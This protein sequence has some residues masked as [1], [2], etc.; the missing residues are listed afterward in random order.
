MA[1]KELKCEHE[2]PETSWG[3]A[4]GGQECG[5]PAVGIDPESERPACAKHA[6]ADSLLAVIEP[7]LPQD[8]GPMG[9]LAIALKNNAAI[10]VIE[11]LAALQE[12]A[13]ARDAE[14]QFNEAMSA[15]QA[16]IGRISPDQ[17]AKEGAKQKWASYAKLDKVLRPIYIKHG[18]SL[19]FNSGVSPLPETVIVECYVSHRG[20]HTRKY[21]APPMPADGKGAKGGDVMTKTF[22]TGAGMSY[23]ARY[24]LKFI[25]NIAVGEDDPEANASGTADRDWLQSQIE[26]IG[27]CETL[28]GLQDAYTS[29]ANTA[30]NQIRDIN[31]Y[32]AIKKAKAARKA[33]LQKGN[34]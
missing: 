32:D 17:Q 1:I 33:E 20:G 27:R 28:E 14:M 26:E 2:S 15:A 11:R 7:Q 5:R 29:A 31:A 8:S 9:L 13:V 23:G 10:D 4:D 30:L 21:S 3:K 19:S 34:Q 6:A 18:F 24:L 12:R 22:A 16:E 25:W